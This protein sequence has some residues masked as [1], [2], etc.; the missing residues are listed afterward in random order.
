MKT[1][2]IGKGHL[3]KFLKTELQIP[4]DMFW[5]DRIANLDD[6][7]LRRLSPDVIV[8]TAGKTD[9][10]YC[11]DNKKDCWDSNVVEPLHLYRRNLNTVNAPFIHISS[12]CIWNGPYKKNGKPFDPNDPPTPACFYAWSKAAFDAFLT[13]EAVTPVA[14][15]RPRQVYSTEIA[16]PDVPARNTLQK[17]LS[18]RALVDT[19]NSMTSAATI[20]KTIRYF[21]NNR[22]ACSIAMNVYDRGVTTPYKVGCML[23][24]A[25]LRDM[26]ELTTKE[27]LDKWHHPRR[28]DA[29]LYDPTFETCIDPPNVEDEL[30]RVID[31]M[32]KSCSGK[33]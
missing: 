8:N 3:G 17:L 9:L 32:K 10:R 5:T 13:K 14:I 25:G 1:L 23:A 20:A 4:D 11:E 2:L 6:A 16:P 15:L 21:I 7:T 24:E 31:D 29:V 18:Y 22:L 33:A 27:E 28:V 26:P 12:G 30:K 19:P